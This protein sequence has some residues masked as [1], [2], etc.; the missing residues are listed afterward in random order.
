MPGANCAS[1]RN[2]ASSGYRSVLARCRYVT[3]YLGHL[4]L[5]QIRASHLDEWRASLRAKG[6]S[7]N[8]LATAHRRLNTALNV[9]KRRK[10]IAENP[11]DQLDPITIDAAE[12][13]TLDAAQVATLL[14]L[15]ASHRL[16]PLFALTA[17]IGLRSAE[18][19]GLRWAALTLSS[20]APRLVVV[21]QLQRLKDAEGKRYLHREKSAKTKAGERTVP[22]SPELASILQAHRTRAKAE[23]ILRGERPA[24]P[25]ADD[26]VFVTERGTPLDG[27][28]VLR[29]LHR[30]CKRAGLPRVSFH[31]LR[32]SAGSIMLANGAQIVDV[33]KILGHSSPIVTANRYAHSFDAGKQQAVNAASVALFKR[34]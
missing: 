32:H 16:Y 4:R 24:E 18:I 12:V 13:T 30:A 25:A 34:A 20:D 31:S 5:D 33:S 26:L 23:R 2:C 17:A 14:E 1:S 28:N 22:L 27:R 6:L 15:L 8:T 9:A 19:I 3:P 11:L 29:T 21:E 7:D 10:M